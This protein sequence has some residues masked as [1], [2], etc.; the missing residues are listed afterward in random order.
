[1]CGS[2]AHTSVELGVRTGGGR[3]G[4]REWKKEC[5]NLY[6]VYTS[7]CLLVEEAVDDAAT[8]HRNKK[9][10]TT[11]HTQHTERT[12]NTYKHEDKPINAFSIHCVLILCVRCCCAHMHREVKIALPLDHFE[13]VFFLYAVRF[14]L[15]ISVWL[16]SCFQFIPLAFLF[17]NSSATAAAAATHVILSFR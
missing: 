15:F 14:F 2:V 4:E 1:M 11:H 16:E 17:Q 12:H 5:R 7:S 8:V 9:K 10:T 3:Y 6:S 13:F